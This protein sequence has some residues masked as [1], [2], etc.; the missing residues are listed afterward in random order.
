MT[1]D[2]NLSCKWCIQRYT[3]DQN[4]GYN[5]QRDEVDYIV[6]SCK[7]R[8][9]RFGIIELTGGEASLWEHLEYGVRRFSEICEYVTLATNGNNPE[10]IIA[11]NLKTWIVSASQATGAQLSK[12]QKYSHRIAYNHHHHKKMPDQ[13][14]QGSL[15]SKCCTRTDSFGR[16]QITMEYIRGKVWYCPDAFAHTEKTG[17]YADIVCDFE[18]TFLG[19]FLRKRYDQRICQYCLGN[20]R[21]WN[22][23]AE[24]NE[25]VMT[26]FKI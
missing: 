6:D 11:L 14:V 18:G 13:P 26:K 12:Y 1:S 4:K 7:K 3:M 19:K 9:L 22:A 23:M 25:D 8:D 20:G 16:S 2:C 5:M 17:V 10:R 21:I 15:P 24:R